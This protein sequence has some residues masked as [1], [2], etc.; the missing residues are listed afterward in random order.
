MAIY[1][2]VY[3][4]HVETIN[5]NAYEKETFIESKVVALKLIGLDD[6]KLPKFKPLRNYS[7]YYKIISV[8]PISG[9]ISD[10]GINKKIK[11][12]GKKEVKVLKKTA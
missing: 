10:V 6:N 9:Y 12:T 2:K 7:E 8:E 1:N 4:G 3:I 11:S 5:P